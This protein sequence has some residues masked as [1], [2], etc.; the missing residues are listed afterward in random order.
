M[1]LIIWNCADAK[2][3]HTA[4]FFVVYQGDGRWYLF[5]QYSETAGDVFLKRTID[6][7]LLCII[8]DLTF[9]I[10][11]AVGALSCVHFMGN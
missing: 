11:T 7:I 6:K 2:N 8:M 9:V 1:E 5:F 10:R 3:K 4:C